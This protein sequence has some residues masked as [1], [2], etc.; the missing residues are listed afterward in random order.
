[1]LL[2]KRIKNIRIYKGLSQ[3]S[4]SEKL[5][6][7]Q[8]S[9]SGYEREAGN[10]KF[11]TIVKIAEALECSIPFLTDIYSTEFDENIWLLSLAKEC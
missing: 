6:I 5:G 2:A 8:S 10:L 1:M 7:E 9:Y 4:L 11:L 3:Q